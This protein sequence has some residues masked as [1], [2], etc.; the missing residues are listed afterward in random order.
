M[1]SISATSSVPWASYSAV[2]S[3][4][5][6]GYAESAVISCRFTIDIPFHPT[7]LD[8]RTR[9]ILKNTNMTRIRTTT[10]IQ[11]RPDGYPRSVT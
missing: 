2:A 4:I 1:T 11:V 7:H 9:V 10:I 5:I 3:I 6:Q 8:P